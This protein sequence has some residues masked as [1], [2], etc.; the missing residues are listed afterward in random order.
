[1]G[2]RERAVQGGHGACGGWARCDGVGSTVVGR[3]GGA[4]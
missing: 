2:V 1:M 3:T 4:G